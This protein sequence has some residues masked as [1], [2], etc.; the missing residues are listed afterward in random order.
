MTFA[1][2]SR[3]GPA[4]AVDVR[5]WMEAWGPDPQFRIPREG[6]TR[7]AISLHAG[8]GQ[9]ATH[10]FYNKEKYFDYQPERGVVSLK[11]G[12][13]G[14][15]VTED[16]IT[17]LQQGLEEEVGDAAALIMYRAGYE[18]GLQDMKL[19]EER[20]EREFGGRTRMSEAHL[21]FVLEQ[22][23]WPLT[24]EGWGAW[25]VDFSQRKQGLIFCDMYESAVARSLGNIGKPVCHMYAGMLAGVFT[26][27]SRH[28]L[29]GIEIQCFSMGEDYCKFLVGA[30]KRINAASFWVEEG[31][32]A[33][34]I[35]S[36]LAK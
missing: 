31:A 35:I 2:L 32:R 22:W 28:E 15:K 12:A 8:D 6:V 36:R 9:R 23:W 3:M 16:F 30:E 4:L 17:G 21:I 7:M 1:R 27:F 10:A 19:F 20:F 14:L 26:Y 18:W 34:E 33:S 5:R 13:R 25:K 11:T 29:S 24:S